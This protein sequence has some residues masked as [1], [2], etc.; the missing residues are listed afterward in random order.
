MSSPQFIVQEVLPAIQA[1]LSPSAVM[2]EASTSAPNIA[3]YDPN[4]AVFQPLTAG[5]ELQADLAAK[6]TAPTFS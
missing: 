4:T 1:A 5:Q 3:H 6:P 2:A